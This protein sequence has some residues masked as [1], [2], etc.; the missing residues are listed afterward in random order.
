MKPIIFHQKC[1]Q[2]H[3]QK[4][5]FK[6]T[7]GLT[8]TPNRTDGLTK[9]FEWFLGPIVYRSKAGKQHNVFVKTIQIDDSNETYSKGGGI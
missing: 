4:L 8:A 1:F 7:I 6:Y 2:E 3:Y 9:A 5:S